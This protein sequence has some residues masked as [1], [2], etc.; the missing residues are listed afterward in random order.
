M[1]GL[2][3]LSNNVYLGRKDTALLPYISPYIGYHDKNGLY[4]KAMSS[5]APTQHV[6]DLF[7]I[8]AGYDH[9]FGE[10]LN[11]GANLNK[12]F[13]NK[14]STSIRSST[15]GSASI[16]SQYTN[17]WIEPQVNFDANLN[18][19]ST[20]YALG[21]QLD[22]NFSLANKMLNIIPAAGMNSGTQHYYDEY[23]I[24][25]LT[26]NDKTLQVK[27]VVANAN[28]FNAI[29]YEFNT[30]VTYRI[31]KWLFTL[32]PTYAIPVS[33]AQITLPAT[34]NLSERTEQEHLSNSFYVELDICH[35]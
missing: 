7:T 35:R 1:F 26:K 21:I 30:K 10:H 24:A 9:S 13:Y 22:H 14:N 12:F 11:A 34:K 18:K 6:L 31:N 27:K 3:Y 23:F 32:T 4:A 16:Y 5:Y 19:K 8:E 28:K 2:N 29:D 33:P 15:K 17:D 25:R 20:D